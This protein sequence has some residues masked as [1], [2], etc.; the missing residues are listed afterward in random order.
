MNWR[1]TAFVF[2]V[3]AV[4]AVVLLRSGDNAADPVGEALLPDLWTSIPFELVLEDV[5]GRTVLRFTSEVNNKGEGD[6][7]LRGD[8][9]GNVQQWV[10]HSQSSHTTAPVDVEVVWGGD[11]HE[12]WHIE[13]VARYW[14]ANLDGTPVGEAFDN[15][16]G[17][18][19]F[20]SINFMSG[21]PGAPDEVRHESAGCGTR[22][23]PEIAMGLSVGWGD[24]YR[25]N[26]EGQF[27]DVSGLAPGTYLLMAEVDPDKRFQEIDRTNNTAATEFTLQI[28][29]GQRSISRGG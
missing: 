20:D 21:L 2:V 8:P 24:Q 26:L 17:F 29:N 9:N 12:H 25:F 10:A 19:I 18:C 28:Q 22:L 4:A 27:I 13:D 11:T 7:L 1:L 23:G 16:V 3:A 5:D 14:V 6:L 15:K